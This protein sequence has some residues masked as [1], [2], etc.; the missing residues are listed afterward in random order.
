MNEEKKLEVWVKVD[1]V[2]AEDSIV[3]VDL[4]PYDAFEVWVVTPRGDA[5][6]HRELT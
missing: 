6:L 2:W 5:E 3:Q 1:G 4:T